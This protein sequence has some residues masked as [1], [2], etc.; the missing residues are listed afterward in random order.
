MAAELAEDAKLLER[1]LG[2]V[3]EDLVAN[4]QVSG[5]LHLLLAAP[6]QLPLVQEEMVELVEQQ[7]I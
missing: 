6:K 7:T 4:L 1:Q 3:V 2:V 5:C